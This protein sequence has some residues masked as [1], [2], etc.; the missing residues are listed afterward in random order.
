MADFNGFA[1]WVEIFRGGKQ[2]DSSGKVHD[3]DMLIDKAVAGFNPQHHE[4]PVVLGHPVDDA[5]A[6]GWVEGVKANIDGGVKRLYAKFRQVVPEF[7][8]MVKSGRY[9]K[10]SASFYP[11]GRL[12]H[13]GWLGAMPPAVKGLADVAFKE[14]EEAILFE[15]PTTKKEKKPMDFNEFMEALKFWKK[16][17]EQPDMT[18]MPVGRVSKPDNESKSFSEADLEAARLEAAKTAKAEAEAAILA[19]FAEAEGRRKKAEA[20]E[21]INGLIES[22]IQAGSIAPAWKDAGI[23]QFME[24]LDADAPIEFGDAKAKKT[25]LEWFTD[26]LES[27]PKLVDFSEIATR[28]KDVKAG[29]AGAKLEALTTAKMKENQGMTYGAAFAEV[30]KQNPALVA[31]YI[32]ESTIQ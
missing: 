16:S 13:V 15:E 23:A 22:G 26:F 24:A 3:G 30:Q 19:E 27:L 32:Q 29:N 1:D 9:K 14:G 28:D 20:K 12:R 18:D 8:E 5:P 21:R 2:T 31:E 4:P 6:Y 11:D 25:G 17:Q 10:R 7:E